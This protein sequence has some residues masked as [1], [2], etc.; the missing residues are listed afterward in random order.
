MNTVFY[1]VAEDDD[2]D[3]RSLFVAARDGVDAVDLM[4]HH[5]RTHAPDVTFQTELFARVYEVPFAAKTHMRT[6]ID[7]GS[8]NHSEE[9]IL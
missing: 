9:R 5:W 8:I 1:V 6:V 7:W 3:D 4:R 2:G